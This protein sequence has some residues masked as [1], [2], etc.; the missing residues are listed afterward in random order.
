[1]YKKVLS[2]GHNVDRLR[3]RNAVIENAGYQ[4]VTTKEARLILDLATKQEFDAFV[5]CSYIVAVLREQIA[6]D[7]K[8]L[9]PSVPLIII[10]D[11]DCEREEKERLRRVADEV[12]IAPPTGSQQ[13]VLDAI[14]RVTSPSEEGL[15]TRL[16]K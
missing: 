15:K 16:N 10:C 11:H 5:I 3:F 2:A 13:V 1:L 12:V 6:R 9:K 8:R 4:V 14:E 7:L